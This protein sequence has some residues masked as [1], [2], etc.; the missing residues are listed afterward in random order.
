ME[1][2][3]V[4]LRELDNEA[5][6]H[7]IDIRQVFEAYEG[8]RRLSKTS[9]AGSMRWVARFGTDYL[10]RRLSDAPPDWW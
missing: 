7:T 5:R 3:S 4:K 6:R 10:L 2:K 1:W 8:K 9:F